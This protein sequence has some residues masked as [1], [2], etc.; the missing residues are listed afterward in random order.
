MKKLKTL[1]FSLIISWGLVNSQEKSL[2]SFESFSYEDFFAKLNSDDE[3]HEKNI[4][5]Q[6]LLKKAKKEK[7]T[8]Y[9][10]GGYE[11]LSSLSKD[12][13]TKLQY[14][15]SVINLS[16]KSPDDFYPAQAYLNKGIIYYRSLDY[17]NSIDN[18]LLALDYSI[19]YP[20]KKFEHLSKLNIAAIKNRLGD[21]QSA[22]PIHLENMTYFSQNIGISNNIDH[23]LNSLFGLSVSQLYLGQHQKVLENSKLGISTARKY[24]RN[25][26]EN[27]FRLGSGAALYWLNE[28]ERSIDSLTKAVPLLQETND[29]QNLI[30]ANYYLTLNFEKTNRN[31]NV[32]GYLKKIDSLVEMDNYIDIK[33]QNAFYYLI[34]YYEKKGNQERQL[35]YLKKTITLDSTLDVMRGEIGLKISNEY[36][37][38][39]LINGKNEIIAKLDRSQSEYKT[40]LIVAIL[41]GSSLFGIFYHKQRKLKQKFNVLLDNKSIG[42][43]AQKPIQEDDLEDIGVPSEI[44]TELLDKLE[45]FEK[46]HGFLNKNCSLSG[47][48]KKW[49]TNTSYLSKTINQYKGKGFTTYVNDLRIDYAIT[50]LRNNH[51]YQKYTISAIASSMGFKSAETFSKLFKTRTE[52]YPSYYLKQLRKMES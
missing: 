42:S 32:L 28:F 6:A 18:S 9:T 10:I 22:I 16:K 48:A 23:Y 38:P 4:Y 20:N 24:N 17:K 43:N 2:N 5:A 13:N 15:D 1:I 11:L 52:I 19:D 30:I 21:F 40:Y 33:A 39:N 44:L 29:N 47:L 26:K 31:K 3:V 50:E 25:K 36:D 41:L 7:N 45:Y 12:K 27:L 8:L 46:E 35:Y 37:I 51:S 14:L 34:D 49:G